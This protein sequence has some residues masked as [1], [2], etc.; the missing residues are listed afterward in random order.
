MQSPYIHTSNRTVIRYNNTKIM[1]IISSKYRKV[2]GIYMVKDTISAL[3][4]NVGCIRQVTT[5][6]ISEPS[7]VENMGALI[8][9]S[10]LYV[11][12]F[13]WNVCSEN[14]YIANVIHFLTGTSHIQHKLPQRVPEFEVPKISNSQTNTSYSLHRLFQKFWSCVISYVSKITELSKAGKNLNP[15]LF[16]LCK[17]LG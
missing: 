16:A 8:T 5:T 17:H 1:Y 4:R 2:A 3:A 12:I 6:Y 9:L 11:L 15:L 10:F 13:P 14:L 7:A